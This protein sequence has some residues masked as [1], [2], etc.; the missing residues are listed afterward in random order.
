MD[1]L[2]GLLCMLP[3]MLI[4]LLAFVFWVWMLVDC[5][6]NEADTG[7]DKLIWGVVIFFGSLL[8]A[9]LYLV[10]R[11]PRRKEQLGR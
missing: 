4:A 7:N 3:M 5:L 10:V 1:E 2:T 11:R 9:F 6:T 8:G